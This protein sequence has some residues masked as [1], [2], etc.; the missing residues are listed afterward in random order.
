MPALLSLCAIALSA[1]YVFVRIVPPV[2]GI[3]V[4]FSQ[5]TG[6]RFLFAA[7][8]VNALG[9]GSAI[10][11]LFN[12][13][14]GTYVFGSKRMLYGLMIVGIIIFIPLCLWGSRALL[15]K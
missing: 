10:W 5:V 12:S 3:S 2:G 1:A 11:M 7:L 14:E 15:P 6:D 9:F 4:L 13:R 8:G